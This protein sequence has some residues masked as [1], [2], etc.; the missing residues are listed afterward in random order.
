VKTNNEGQY[1]FYT[2]KP[3]PYPGHS[4]PAHI[5]ITVKEPDKAEYWIDDF[6][7]DDDPLLTAEKRHRQQARGGNG[8]L[9]LQVKNGMLTANRDIILGRNVPGYPV[10]LSNIQSAFGL[11]LLYMLR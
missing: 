9:R 8:I 5:H 6:M 11:G 1:A 7:F 4:D 2:L 3:A 10:A